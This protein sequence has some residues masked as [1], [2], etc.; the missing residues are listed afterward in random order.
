M[1]KTLTLEDVKNSV[2]YKWRKGQIVTLLTVWGIIVV[3]SFFLM[4]FV[5]L[6]EKEVNLFGVGILT[7]LGCTVFYGLLFVGFILF[8]AYKNKY[9]V[10]NYKK[11]SV[12]EVVLNHLFT[13][14]LYTR[15][16]SYTVEFVEQ[17]MEKRVATNPYFS[18]SVFSKFTPEEFNNQKVVGLYD[19][20][21]ERFYIVKKVG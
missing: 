16:I 5:V 1:E 18:S 8:Y 12:H 15:S 13:S 9:L 11:F 17:G 10:D 6:M 19:S 4:L 20:S 7:W 3:A 21:L 14:H 2:E